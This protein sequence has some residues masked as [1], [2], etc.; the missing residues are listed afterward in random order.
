ML[1]H[2]DGFKCIHFIC[3]AI[4]TIWL[5]KTVCDD[6]KISYKTQVFSNVYNSV[7][8]CTQQNC[9]KAGVTRPVKINHLSINYT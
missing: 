1:Q 4:L 2:L 7:K 8:I 5:P 3:M 6:S 9:N